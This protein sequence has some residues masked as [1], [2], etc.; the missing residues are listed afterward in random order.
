MKLSDLIKGY[1]ASNGLSQDD[2]AALSGLSKPYISMLEN[3][4]NTKTG[5]PIVPSLHT[6]QKLS[7]AM[8]M[9]LDDMIKKI[10]DDTV[11][12]ISEIPSPKKKL[13]SMNCTSHEKEILRKYRCLPAPVQGAVDA[14]IDAQ[15]AL[16]CPRVKNEEEI[17]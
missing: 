13:C 15:Y 17:S 4:K 8:N 11:I 2:M 14:M 16:A 7:H 6:L 9:E 10:D 1:R 5:K 3:E 12:S